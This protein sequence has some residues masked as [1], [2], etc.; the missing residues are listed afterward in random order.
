LFHHHEQDKQLTEAE[1]DRLLS[2]GAT[3]QGMVSHNEPSAADRRIWLVRVEVWFK[4]RQRVEFSEELDS[5]YQPA[6]GSPEAQRIV[7]ARGGEQLRHPDRIP[8]IQ[9]PLSDGSTVP[10]RY[11]AATTC[12]PSSGER[13]TTTSSKR[14]GNSS[15]LLKKAS[16]PARPGTCRRTARTAAHRSTRRRRPETPT[17][18]A[19]SAASR[20]R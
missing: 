16:A 2:E 20:S 9:L 12:R 3:I 4:D 19:S 13:C 15:P 7:A 1:H 17:R 11:D 10:V 8:K 18:T 5:L 14:K 6:P